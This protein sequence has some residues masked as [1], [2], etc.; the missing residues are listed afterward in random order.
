MLTTIIIDNNNKLNNGQEHPLQNLSNCYGKEVW[1]YFMQK[2]LFNLSI[3]RSIS[4][5]R[6]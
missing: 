2:L 3:L 4:G 6:H 5:L 1:Y